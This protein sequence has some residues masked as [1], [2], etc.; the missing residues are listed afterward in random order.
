MADFVETM[1]ESDRCVLGLV[2]DVD[3]STVDSLLDAAFR[4]MDRAGVV[5][6]DLGELTFID[7]S[8]LGA[9]VRIRN[10]A[11]ERAKTLRV[12]NVPAATERL[13]RITGLDKAL[14]MQPRET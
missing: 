3:I 11:N 7:S 1:P 14:R 8:G 5:E 6:L 10:E 4:C 13:L 12:T 9:L 2:G